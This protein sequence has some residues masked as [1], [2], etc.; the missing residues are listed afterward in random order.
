MSL[1]IEFAGTP[2]GIRLRRTA[3]HRFTFNYSAHSVTFDG[4]AIDP[5]GVS[6][7]A[8]TE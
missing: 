1:Q 4:Q 6:I 7:T 3:S 8:L 5:A 2:E